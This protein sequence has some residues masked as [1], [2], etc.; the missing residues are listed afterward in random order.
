M[1]GTFFQQPL[2]LTLNVDGESWNQGD[3]IS[4]KLIVKNHGA[5]SL[6]LNDYGVRLSFGISKE[7]KAKSD[8]AFTMHGEALFD[9]G[10]VAGG[11]EME[12]PFEFSLPKDAPISEKSK[13]LYLLCG[14]LENPFEN[15]ILELQIAPYKDITN[16]FQ[17][18]ENLLRFKVKSLKNKKDSIEAIMVVPTT[19]D[20]SSVQQLKVIVKMDQDDLD[21]N[22]NF[23]LKKISFEDGVVSS[24]DS[25]L[26]VQKVLSP[27]DYLIYGDAFNQDK[28][29]SLLQ[30]VIEEVKVKP[31]I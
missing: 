13:S 2:E 14:K 25:T 30:E 24:K 5:E 27:K 28:V 22:F 19:K 8:K 21:I 20:Y 3:T 9:S 23:K 1:K 18:F 6:S 16:L 31:L 7:I 15:G 11:S 29:L 26:K 12:L 4:G 10:D 17:V